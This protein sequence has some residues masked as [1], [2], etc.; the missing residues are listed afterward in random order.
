MRM[1][2]YVIV[3]A[4]LLCIPHALKAQQPDQPLK[5]Q[6]IVQMVK[7][8][9]SEDLIIS[10]IQ[11]FPGNYDVRPPALIALK[12][13]G[14][15]NPVLEAMSKRN[16]A[17]AI[18]PVSL[19]PAEK[20]VQV[21]ADFV[22]ELDSCVSSGGDS[23]ICRILLTNKGGERD[24]KL[25]LN[26]YIIDE[27]G[28]QYAGTDV[29][30]GNKRRTYQFETEV[31][32]TLASQ[33]TVAASL[34]FQKIK[35]GVKTVK[36][37]RLACETD[38]ENFPIEFRDVTIGAKYVNT[39][40]SGSNQLREPAPS[41]ASSEIQIQRNESEGVLQRLAIKYRWNH[42]I[43]SD[44]S[45]AVDLCAATLS[46]GADFVEIG[47]DPGKSFH[48]QDCA[49]MKYRIPRG[50]LY[51]LKDNASKPW[52]A[53]RDMV[54]DYVLVKFGIV[55]EGKKE[56]KKELYLYPAEAKIVYGTH[57]FTIIAVTECR[58]CPTVSCNDCAAGFRM[59]KEALAKIASKS[60]VKIGSKV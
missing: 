31:R 41:T 16:S 34:A 4:L 21:H 27:G 59:I 11:Q 17:V 10:T 32:S 24:L 2:T 57:Y 47:G 60:S 54:S 9:L 52:Y 8:G 26:S 45:K 46:V 3:A 13:D 56:S 55:N 19:K 58:N 5:N 30:I 42:S 38:S 50:K 15:T 22:F 18:P 40:G 25:T 28:D 48:G 44:P 33:I 7:E 6:D 39:S 37:L 12:K 43:F 51:E 53:A 29:S 36:L 14:V 49:A 23:L 35:P 1:L 20:R